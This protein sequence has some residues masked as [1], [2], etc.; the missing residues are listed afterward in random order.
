MNSKPFYQSKTFYAGV[1]Y[2]LL[3]LAKAFGVE[4]ADAGKYDQ[5]LELAAGGIAFVVLRAA[6]KQPIHFTAPPSVNDIAPVSQP[7][8]K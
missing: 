6:T 2:F 8:D 7:A 4:G 3:A 5:I 1:L